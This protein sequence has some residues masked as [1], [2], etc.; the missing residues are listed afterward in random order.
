MKINST[1]NS[2]YIEGDTVLHKLN[3]QT[4]IIAALL[5]LLGA[6]TG[7]GWVLVGAGLFSMAGVFIARV[8]VKEILY[9]I[10]RMAWFFLAIAIF[11]VLF[12]P[13]FY[14]DLPSWFPIT[15]SHEGLALGLESSVR[16]LNILFVSLVLVR[17]TSSEDW[18]SGLDKLLGPM[19]Q[20]L[21]VV[22]ELL[23][24]AVM[25]VKFLPMIFAETE[26]RFAELRKDKD[27]RGLN[28]LRSMLHSILEFIAWIFSDLERFQP[29][30][31]ADKQR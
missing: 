23:A 7:N 16:L 4:K 22:R 27:E 31:S 8:P 24:V 14:I 25:A 13:G 6:G 2:G 26:E 10:R 5:L 3:S 20:R 18:M 19:S 29:N 11:P 30:T 9:L 21:P 15:I 1:N 12:T 17:T 28:K